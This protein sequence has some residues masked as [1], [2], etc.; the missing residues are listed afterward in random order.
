MVPAREAEV[1]LRM[2]TTAVM[3]RWVSLQTSECLSGSGVSQICASQPRGCEVRVRVWSNKQGPVNCKVYDDVMHAGE[4]LRAC[5]S[6]PGV[7]T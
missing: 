2:G 5:G 1:E 7:G 4:L 3:L 6:Q